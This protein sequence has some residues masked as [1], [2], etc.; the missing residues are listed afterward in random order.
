M[1]LISAKAPRIS[2]GWRK[3]SGEPSA[4]TPRTSSILSSMGLTL[5][6]FPVDRYAQAAMTFSLG[7]DLNISGGSPANQLL[8]NGSSLRENISST[9]SSINE[10]AWE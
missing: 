9:S 2:A 10:T 4:S 8:N 1:Q 3:L 6:E 7:C 5:S